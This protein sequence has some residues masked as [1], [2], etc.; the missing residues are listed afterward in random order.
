MAR[1]ND[2]TLKDWKDGDKVT[3]DLYEA[4]REILRI[5][6]NDNHDR[7]VTLEIDKPVQDKRLDDL[8]YNTTGTV[9]PMTFKELGMQNIT[10]D[11]IKLGYVDQAI[12]KA[13]KP[14]LDTLTRG[15]VEE[16]TA[17]NGQTVVNLTNSY[18]VGGNQITVEIDGVPQD[19][20]SYTETSTTSITL[21]EALVAGQKVVVTIGKVDP[22]ADARFSSLTTQMVDIAYDVKNYGATGTGSNNDTTAI[23]TVLNLAKT[24]GSVHCLIPDGVYWITNRLT[25]YKNTKITMGKGTVLLRKW[26]AG[27]FVNGE[28]TDTFTGYS[29]NGNIIIEGGTLDGNASEYPHITFDAIGLA[30]GE[31]LV[32]RNIT[33]LDVCGTH[34]FDLNAVKNVLIEGC[35][36]KGYD[37][38]YQGDPVGSNFR[39]AIQ[40]ANHT[41]TGYTLFGSFDGTPCENITV[42]NCYFGASANLPAWPVSVGNHTS[43]YNL[44]NSNI[45][46]YNNVMDGMIFAGVRPFKFKDVFIHHNLF[47][48]CQ[49]GVRNS[50]ANGNGTDDGGVPQSSINV[51]IKNNIFRDTKGYNIYSVGWEKTGT[52]G[53]VDSL[54]IEGNVFENQQG[55]SN[56]SNMHLIFVNNVSI[57]DNLTKGCYRNINISYGSSVRIS[58]NEGY[59]STQEVIFI[60]EPDVAYQNIGY[61]KEI[62]IHHNKFERCGQAGINMN[63]TD[64]FEISHNTVRSSSTITDNSKSGIITGTGS[65]NGRIIHNKVRMATSGNQNKYGVEV[66]GT[67]LNIQ[68]FNNDLEGKTAKQSLPAVA[69]IFDGYYVTSPNG[70]R[71][72]AT[73]SDVGATVYTAG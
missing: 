30:R 50:N 24:N 5:A 63:G 32:F 69:S 58:G 65:K 23:Q 20:T 4:D 35:S 31:N 39:E 61:T 55:L 22:N 37:T 19:E 38:T 52:V 21:S 59:D 72:K 41:A 47:I 26:N 57:K 16:S 8:E 40:I 66:T 54:K 48:G 12:A 46:I 28:S 3:S 34:A 73:V 9:V 70:T 53:K 11:D 64:G 60:S 43:S 44:Y 10:F 51:E 42:R 1:I 71:Y 18:A 56:A 49:D 17:T 2:G 36:F 25:I 15:I 29:G 13:W 33:I 62:F 6:N 67:C 45:H 27:F 14:S 68:V 7:I